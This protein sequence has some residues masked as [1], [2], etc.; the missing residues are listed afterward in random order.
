MPASWS[1]NRRTYAMRPAELSNIGICMR[2]PRRETITDIDTYAPL[3]RMYAPYGSATMELGAA[4]DGF[5]ARNQGAAGEGSPASK[6]G[7]R[8]LHFTAGNRDRI[9]HRRMPSLRLSRLHA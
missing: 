6:G 2:A 3:W 9:L 5:P 8:V 4:G 1:A 7:T